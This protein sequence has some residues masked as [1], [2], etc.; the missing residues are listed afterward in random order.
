[1]ENLLVDGQEGHDHGKKI[2]SNSARTSQISCLTAY[3]STIKAKKIPPAAHSRWCPLG[4]AWLSQHCPYCSCCVCRLLIVSLQF[5]LFLKMP[6]AAESSRPLT[7][8]L[9]TRF[10]RTDSFARVPFGTFK[11]SGS[12]GR[13]QAHEE[14]GPQNL[15][16]NGA[17][18][19]ELAGWDQNHSMAPFAVF[20]LNLFVKFESVS[21]RNRRHLTRMK[22]FCPILHSRP[23][24][25]G[26]RSK[27]VFFLFVAFPFVKTWS[28][29]S[30]FPFQ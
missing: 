26:H 3:R 15:S 14:Y 21:V 9:L 7:S 19:F 1:M 16:K 12:A 17:A 18:F 13:T 20:Q 28:L 27:I 23:I 24:S 30:P 11:N 10:I 5:L 2:S 29:P 8:S 6:G 22:P 4:S 25:V